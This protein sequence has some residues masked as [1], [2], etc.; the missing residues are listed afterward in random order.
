MN[1]YCLIFIVLLLASL[2]QAQIKE[3]NSANGGVFTP[4][5][6]LRALIVFVSYKDQNKANPSF[7]NQ[8]N[9]LPDWEGSGLPAFVNPITGE[10]PSYIFNKESD[11]DSYIDKVESNFSKTFYLM[12]NGKFKLIGELF[13]DKNGRPT[14]VEID[15]T[16][17]YSWTQMN[18]RAVAAM[19][20]INPNFDFSRFDQ[21]K[22]NP[23]FLFD[24]SDTAK[25][26]AD[27]IVDFTIFV[28]RYSRHW[29]QAPTKGMKAW[30]GSGGGFAGTGIA[31]TKRVGKHRFAEGFTMTYNSGVFVHEVAHVLFNAPHIMGVNNVIGDYFYLMSAGWGVMAPIGIFNG[32]NAWERWYCGFIEP[33]ADIQSVKD[34]QNGGDSFILGDYF[35]TG[36]AARI[37]IPFSGGQHLWLENH[38]KIHPLDE[39]PWKGKVLGHGD[40]LGGSA[41]GVYIYVEAIAG[42]RTQIFSPLSNRANGIKVLHAGGN[43]D[44][45]LHEDI[46]AI[47]NAWGNVMKSFSRGEANPISGLN[48][49]YRYPFDTNND[50]KIILDRNY[51]SSRTEW[52]APIFREKNNR[53]SFVNYYG[54]FGLYDVVKNGDYIAPV[55]FQA[56]DYLDLNTN[57]M[58]LNYPKYNGS[59]LS[60]EPY[61]LNGLG[62]KLLP[63][64]GTKD[65]L[66]KV[67][68]SRIELC[69]DSRW[70]GN[71]VLPN[72][73]ENENADLEIGACTSLLLDKSKTPN[74]H[75]KTEEGDFVNPTTFRIAKNATM[76]LKANSKLIL[77]DGTKFIIEEGG[78]LI[79][80]K[81]SKFII[82][83]NASL[84]A[85]NKSIVLKKSAKIINNSKKKEN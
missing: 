68:Y 45:H 6:T 25:Y 73:T 22:N 65:I 31:P 46:P 3:R 82:K 63:I 9:H 51:N 80:E 72:I 84:I 1:R 77:K 50:G 56:G 11:F 57:P 23:N 54:S 41:A 12:S 35:T 55:A 2:S 44:Y 26:K 38:C 64:E 60:L 34:L 30:I 24:N 29:R 52:M 27:G 74:R 21:R 36:A 15:P 43:Y 39:H 83:N 10:C 4:K 78:L 17:G 13:K 70:T 59:K 79:L 40:T 62:V 20:K 66:V 47:K 7:R 67:S 53:D 28:H 48:N 71:I 75:L 69:Q 37:E 19:Q 18:E 58:P 32:F 16:G 33:V 8:G 42:S 81:K 5:G 61:Y 76:L 49:F 14:V 85:D